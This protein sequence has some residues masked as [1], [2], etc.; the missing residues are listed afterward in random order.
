M[1]IT[2]KQFEA[3]LKRI[4]KDETRNLATKKQLDDVNES[5]TTSIDGLAKRVDSFLSVE[6]KTHLYDTHPRLEKRLTKIEKN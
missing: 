1:N 5:L 3:S 2:I 6:W 4:I